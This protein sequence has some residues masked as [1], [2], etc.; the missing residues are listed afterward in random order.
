MQR[1]AQTSKKDRWL[2]LWVTGQ[3]DSRPFW[4][5]IDSAQSGSL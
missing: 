5:L 1:S 4:L 2:A 3:L